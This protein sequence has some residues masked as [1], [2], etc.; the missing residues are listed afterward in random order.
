MAEQINK[1]LKSAVLE[2]KGLSKVFETDELQT[3]ALRSIEL[4][5]YSGEYL[6]ISGPSGCGKSTL[7][8]IL[9]LLDMS[10]SGEYFIDGVNVSKLTLNQAAEIRNAKIGFI[11]QSFNLIDELNVFDNVALPLRYHHSKPNKHE[12]AEKVKACLE[13]VGLGHR[14]SHKPSQLSGGQQQRVAIARALVAEPTILL[15][16][17]PTGN[18]DSKS[19]DQV[20]QILTDLNN[21]GTTICMV[22]HDPRYADMASR[23]LKLLDGELLGEIAVKEPLNA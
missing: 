3:Y 8:S 20:M 5:V 7:L 6:S 18:L 13:K 9:G 1:A 23:Q 4:K 17:E 16:D 19:G 14:M 2:M 22:T 15:V 12:I 21:G 11:F 10:T